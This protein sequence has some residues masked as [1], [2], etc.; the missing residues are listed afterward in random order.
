MA[1]MSKNKSHAGAKIGLT[2]GVAA[3][4]G[5]AYLLVG[6]KEA[7]KRRKALKVFAIKA[8]KEVMKEAKTAKIFNQKMYHKAVEVVMTKYRGLKNVDPKEFSK[9]GSDLK[10]H[11]ETIKKQIK[12]GEK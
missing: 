4:A 8:K 7:A 1:D 5:A 2:L 11:W 12:V 9:I 6:S 3:A 10:K